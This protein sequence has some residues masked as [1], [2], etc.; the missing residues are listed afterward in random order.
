MGLPTYPW[1]ALEVCIRRQSRPAHC[2]FAHGGYGNSILPAFHHRPIGAAL[3]WPAVPGTLP[4]PALCH[5]EPGLACGPAGIPVPAGVALTHSKTGAR[6]DG[7]VFHL[8]DLV[9]G[10]DF[11]TGPPVTAFKTHRGIWK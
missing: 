5:L 8:S 2:G 3:V 9:R 7:S 11:D 6:M 10:S 1:R 4:V